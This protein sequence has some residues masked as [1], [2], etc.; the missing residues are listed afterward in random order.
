MSRIVMLDI[1][2]YGMV[3]KMKMKW[4]DCQTKYN[5][6]CWKI[7]NKYKNLKLDPEERYNLALFGL[8]KAYNSFDES[9]GATFLTHATNV[10]YQV[11]NL[12]Y[13]DANAKKRQHDIHL[14]IN[15]TD[16]EG[17][18]FE[19]ILED[20][21]EFGYAHRERIYEFMCEF[22]KIADKDGLMFIDKINGM[23]VDDILIKYNYSKRCAYNHINRGRDKF[24]AYLERKD[25]LL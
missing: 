14:D 11:F 9:R 16:E 1:Y 2:V 23:K 22:E 3:N 15:H 12:E 10:I 5:P 25:V 18:R 21:N 20:K 24:I 17:I 13:R 8:W 7:A 19:E 6:L 4:E